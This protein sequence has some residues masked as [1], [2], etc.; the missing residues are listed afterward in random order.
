MEVIA[1]N[2][3]MIDGAEIVTGTDTLTAHCP[4]PGVKV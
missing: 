4:G 1:L 2:V 3:G